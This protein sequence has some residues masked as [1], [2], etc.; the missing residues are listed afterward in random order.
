MNTD[1]DPGFTLL[2]ARWLALGGAAGVAVSLGLAQFG[3][4]GPWQGVALALALLALFAT[5]TVALT[6]GKQQD[7]L[8]EQSER[9]RRGEA[10]V[11]ALQL[12]IS[13]HTKLEQEL[14]K[15]KQAAE[16]AVMAKGEFLATMSHEIRTPLNGIVPML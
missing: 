3:V 15:A 5:T 6:A 12:E 4:Q 8:A 16:S 13:R 1:Q 10:E 2:T 14:T 9:G 11:S 7:L